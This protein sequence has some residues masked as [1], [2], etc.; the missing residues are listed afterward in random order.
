[1]P[2]H[3]AALTVRMTERL[4]PEECWRLLSRAHVGRV[5]VHTDGEIDIFPIN[6]VATRGEIFFRSAPG[7]KLMDIA[8]N[9]VVAFESD[10]RRPGHRWSVVVR[11]IAQ[12]LDRDDEIEAS[13]V[14]D[15]HTVT[16]TEK[17]NYVRIRPTSVTGRRL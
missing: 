1:M 8:S 5:A 9:P 3:P 16:S 15:L 4:S 11:G 14:L 17:W 13:G 2:G 10:G 7:S 6:F 12:R